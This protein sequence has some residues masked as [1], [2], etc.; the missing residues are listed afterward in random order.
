MHVDQLDI[1]RRFYAA[2]R[3]AL[4]TYALGLTRSREAAEDA[5]QM[6]FGKILA[7][8]RLPRD[9]RPYVFRCTRNAAIDEHRIRKRALPRDSVFNLDQA[10]GN[11][12]DP[13]LQ[14]Q[15][16]EQLDRLSADERESIVLKTYSGMTFN[17]IAQVRKVSINT[18][19][20]WYRRGLDKLRGFLEEDEE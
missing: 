12:H 15:L 9:L 8:R 2:N 16:A 20:S 7:R 3:Q 14:L 19:A 4:Y 11:G 18:A 10:T 1:V 6:A 5:V 17:E 13:A